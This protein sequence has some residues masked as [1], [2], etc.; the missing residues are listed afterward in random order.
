MEYIKSY[1]FV[2]EH[3]KVSQYD[4][5]QESFNPEQVFGVFC[6]VLGQQQ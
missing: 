2:C 6:M 3:V 5:R 1:D 4:G